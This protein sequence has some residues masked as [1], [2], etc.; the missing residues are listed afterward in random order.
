MAQEVAFVAPAPPPDL[1]PAPKQESFFSTFSFGG[2][3]AATALGVVTALFRP[4][5]AIADFYADVTIEETARDDLEITRHPVES[6]SEITDHAYKQ[7]AE[8]IIRCGWSNSGF[9]ETGFHGPGFVEGIYD[10]LL[11]LQY[12]RIPFTVVTGKRT[13]V[14]ML[15]ASLSQTT[16]EKTENALIV[17]VVCRQIILVQ[18]QTTQVAPRAQQAQPE[19]TAATEATGS[20]QPA[21][22]PN[23]SL[24][25]KA[26]GR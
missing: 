19:N 17:T 15:I 21:A 10:Q 11:N 2:L 9:D 14:N 18:T 26:F 8:V 13:Y 12:S 5:R 1:P 24:L 23:T 4:A 6:G 22:A 20:Q 16:D 25:Y 7:P 3:A